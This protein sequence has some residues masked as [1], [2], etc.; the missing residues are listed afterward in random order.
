MCL[1]LLVPHLEVITGNQSSRENLN[2]QPKYKPKFLAGNIYFPSRTATLCNQLIQE[3][4]AF[5]SSSFYISTVSPFRSLTTFF[6]VFWRHGTTVWLHSFR[7]ITVRQIC[8]RYS[9]LI[10]GIPLLCSRLMIGLHMKQPVIEDN[11]SGMWWEF[12]HK[13]YFGRVSCCMPIP[14]FINTWHVKTDQ[15]LKFFK[16]NVSFSQAFLSHAIKIHLHPGLEAN[17]SLVTNKIAM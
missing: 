17:P 16:V 9:S 5:M 7:N 2:S 4:W 10:V 6:V 12:M 11:L 3:F 15:T 1:W 8:V 13:P 14:C